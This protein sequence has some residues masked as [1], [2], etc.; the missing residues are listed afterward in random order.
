[1]K[2]LKHGKV[3]RVITCLCGC[4]FQYDQNDIQYDIHFSTAAN[5]TAYVICPD[6]GAR[7]FLQFPIQ[8]YP[9]NEDNI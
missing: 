8:N 3:N 9:L 1:M 4:E 7:I 5:G 6:C 2:I